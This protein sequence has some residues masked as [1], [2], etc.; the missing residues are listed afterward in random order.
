M[1][2]GEFA[3]LCY[4]LEKTPGRLA[5]VAAAA[6]YL[7][8]LEANEIR[9][10]VAFL[11]GRAFPIADPRTLEIGPGALADAY[12]IPE[13]Q[14]GRHAPLTVAEAADA[15]GKIA[16][17]AGKGSRSEKFARLKTLIERTAADERP[18]LFRI[19]H[20]EL[21]VGLHD[22]LIQEAIAKA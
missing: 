17:V 7:R 16:E 11:S 22:G 15:F 3:V 1:E 2:F 6:A 10:G 19:L 21:R 9:P 12:R 4:A 13:S 8:R 14:N 18:I 5:K 20:N